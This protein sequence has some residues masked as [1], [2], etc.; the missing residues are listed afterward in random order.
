MVRLGVAGPSTARPSADFV[1][2][3]NAELKVGGLEETITVSGE[4]PIVD[5]QT[6][7]KTQ[8]LDLNL[9]QSVPTA[10]GYAAVMLLIPSMVV[11]GGG[12]SNVQ[13]SPGMIVFGG[14][15]GRGNEGQSQLDGL[16]TGAAINGG[17]VS[18]YG[19]LET[20]QEVVMTTAAGLGEAEVGGP[21]INFIPKTGGNTFQNHFYGSGMSD[22]NLHTHKN[23]PTLVLA[24]KRSGIAGNRYLHFPDTTP[25]ANLQ[26]TMLEKLGIPMEKFGDSTG[27]LTRLAGV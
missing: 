7:K 15:G 26:L 23:V 8:T 16:G 27:Q 25:L 3:A 22:S 21:I 1:A 19:Q 5:V 24:G 14:R 9:L 17:G 10:R 11:S 2:T 4:S 20:A 18:G 13:L 12:N 6:T